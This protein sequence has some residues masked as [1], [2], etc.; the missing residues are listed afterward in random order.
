MFMFK[1]SNMSRKDLINQSAATTG[2]KSAVNES[3][4]NAKTTSNI[5]RDGKDL[6]DTIRISAKNAIP[7]HHNLF[8]LKFLLETCPFLPPLIP[9][10]W[11]FGDVSSGFKVRVGSRIHT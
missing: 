3:L 2:K 4:T 11:N 1:L 9:L 8:S 5:R 6:K 7:T 10:F